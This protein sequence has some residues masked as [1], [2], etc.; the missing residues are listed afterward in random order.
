MGFFDDGGNGTNAE[1]NECKEQE[2]DFQISTLSTL[3]NKPRDEYPESKFG[4]I[5]E[6]FQRKKI[7][8]LHQNN[9]LRDL[10]TA[11]ANAEGLERLQIFKN[12]VMT[13]QG[14][15]VPNSNIL[16]QVVVKYGGVWVDHV[17]RNKKTITHVLAMQLPPKKRDEFRTMRVVKP[18]WVM[19]C[20]RLGLMVEWSRWRV[21]GEGESQARLGVGKAG[22]MNAVVKQV[23]F[24]ERNSYKVTRQH[25]LVKQALASVALSNGEMGPEN[26]V[27][28]E[29]DDSNDDSCKTPPSHQPEHRSDLEVEDF[30]Q[31]PY[32]ESNEEGSCHEAQ[33]P[34]EIFEEPESPQLPE[35]M[36]FKSEISRSTRSSKNH[37]RDSSSQRL[38]AASSATGSKRSETN[39]SQQ[40]PPTL[41]IN[42]VEAYEAELIIDSRKH[43]FNRRPK[44]LQG[45]IKYLV[46]WKGY[47][48]DDATWEWEHRLRDDLGGYVFEDMVDEYLQRKKLNR[49][50]PGRKPKVKG[51]HRVSKKT[52]I[53]KKPL[54]STAGRICKGLSRPSDRTSNAKSYPNLSSQRSST[55]RCFNLTSNTAGHG[56][57]IHQQ[58]LPQP[59]ELPINNNA[60]E[61]AALPASSSFGFDSFNLSQVDLCDVAPKKIDE[62]GSRY[63]QVK[64]PETLEGPPPSHQSRPGEFTTFHSESFS[65]ANIEDADCA[66]DEDMEYVPDYHEQAKDRQYPLRSSQPGLNLVESH[67]FCE[68]KETEIQDAEYTLPSRP[69]TPPKSTTTRLTEIPNSFSSVKLTSEAEAAEQSTSLP[70]SPSSESSPTAESHLRKGFFGDVQA[71]LPLSP[72]ISQSVT[73]QRQGSIDEAQTASLPLS[74]PRETTPTT[75]QKRPASAGLSD[76]AYKKQKL[77]SGLELKFHEV[78]VS[79]LSEQIVQAARNITPDPKT[80]TAEEFNAALLA[81]PRI[82]DATVLNPNFLTKYFGESRLSYLSTA[83]ANLRTRVQ[84][85]LAKI[86]PPPRRERRYIMHVD[87]DCFFAAVSIRDRPELKDKPVAICH[88]NSTNSMSSEIASCNYIARGFGVRN[89]SWMASAKKLCSDLVTLGYEFEKYEEA[90]RAF[91]DV[92]L[93]LGGE[94]VQAVSVDEA[95]VDISN[96]VC[97]AQIGE[98]SGEEAAARAIAKMVRDQCRQRTGCEVSIGIGM[99]IAMAKLALKKAKPAGQ[100]VV[101]H[102][103]VESFLDG[104]NIGAFPGIGSHTTSKISKEFETES[105]SG[106]RA[107]PKDRLKKALGPKIGERV[108]ELCRGIDNT[109]VGAAEF[110]RES[111]SVNVNW[112][113]RFTNQ[114][115]AENFV[116]ELTLE[117]ENRMK[118]EGVKGTKLVLKV[119]KRASG[120]PFGTEKFLG[121]GKC[122]E[123]N[124]SYEFGVP[125]GDADVI[126]KKCVELL[127]N[128]QI[129]PGELRGLC[130]SMKGLS[131]SA[132]NDGGQMKL[133]FAVMPGEETKPGDGPQKVESLVRSLPASEAQL[134]PAQPPT[135]GAYVKP[136]V[137]TLEDAFAKRGLQVKMPESPMAPPE[138]VPVHSKAPVQADA[139]KVSTG[140]VGKPMPTAQSGLPMLLPPAQERQSAPNLR[141]SF[142]PAYPRVITLLDSFTTRAGPKSQSMDGGEFVR[143]LLPTREQQSVTPVSKS[144]TGIQQ[145]ALPKSEERPECQ[146]KSPFVSTQFEIPSPSQIDIECL[147]HLPAPMR[148]AILRRRNARGLV[149]KPIFRQED[150]EKPPNS[151]WDTETWGTFSQS[152]RD[153]IRAE[154]EE[155][156]KRAL[157]RKNTLS[158]KKQTAST[159][160]R[161]PS[162]SPAKKRGRPPFNAAVIKAAPIPR[163]FGGNGRTAPPP[164]PNSDRQ[165]PHPN[166]Y[167]CNGNEISSWFF[168]PLHEGGAGIN[169]DVFALYDPQARAAVVSRYVAEREA[170]LEEAAEKS[171]EEAWKQEQLQN[172]VRIKATRLRPLLVNS[173]SKKGDIMVG[174]NDMAKVRELVKTWVRECGSEDS[175]E[176]PE[177]GDVELLCEF[178]RAIVIEEKRLDKAVGFVRWFLSFVG[179]KE[180][181]GIVCD[182][183]VEAVGAAAEAKGMGPIIF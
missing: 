85:T 52:N 106:I 13:A 171:A 101:G 116:Y 75:C 24:G 66:Y 176:E 67:L 89:G 182:S 82:R 156:K 107:I 167:D 165:M 94:R 86:P 72:P 5:N 121:C 97:D 26:I 177:D 61:E 16:R 134:K 145:W 8:L 120:A 44:H 1:N 141:R 168:A 90:T 124:K 41:V 92:I 128:C 111:I 77:I 40:P 181:W 159:A 80:Q 158:P 103:E 109:L 18:E 151:Q 114:V 138:P 58:L 83:K 99:N 78:P 64:V 119:A 91:Y 100:Y 153:E 17:N 87:F 152:V 160:L 29:E 146:F 136:K 173:V 79:I 68:L 43:P 129:S 3:T 62:G 147:P 172:A 132:K 37:S 6:Y 22:K 140:S 127:R 50:K 21:G 31:W 32:Q 65:S 81:N 157:A 105:V 48:L 7:K 154:H 133:Q 60:V 125:T 10:H 161:S 162:K 56:K 150:V 155:E 174:S 126:G 137:I 20:V 117:V 2:I 39:T 98:L 122:E 28:E 175:G 25:E 47:G 76:E 30:H 74:P 96:M 139:I 135:L 170:R 59:S 9:D 49:K 142:T 112:G 84:Q 15:T 70:S 34:T 46:K 163:P 148:E 143:P 45:K 108:Y 23:E 12:C 11:A 38:T 144:S 51:L 123:V 169:S 110:H 95:L 93:A 179:K 166:V 183:V 178:L 63:H 131:D 33:P 42:G 69:S 130:V 4:G 118:S 164:A 149:Y 36:S 102:S 35:N 73:P 115:Q 53:E 55:R 14:H 19:E 71:P 57:S 88:G 54:P 180:A 27:L 104:L 113:V